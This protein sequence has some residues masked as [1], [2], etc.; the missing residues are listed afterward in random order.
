MA[1]C[2]PTRWQW[3]YNDLD[4]NEVEIKLLCPILKLFAQMSLCRRQAI[5]RTNAGMLFIGPLG[6]NKISIYIGAFS[7][8]KIHSEMSSE[9]RQPFCLNFKVLVKDGTSMLTALMSVHRQ[10]LEEKIANATKICYFQ[11][12]CYRLCCIRDW[13]Q[14]PV[15]VSVWS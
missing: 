11:G 8:T 7:F 6:T 3:Q 2:S 10:C 4:G 14:P 13:N 9:K 1:V 12:C 5:I 15:Y